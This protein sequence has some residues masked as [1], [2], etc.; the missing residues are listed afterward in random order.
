MN[1]LWQYLKML[2]NGNTTKKILP[3]QGKKIQM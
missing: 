3:K 1:T 2:M